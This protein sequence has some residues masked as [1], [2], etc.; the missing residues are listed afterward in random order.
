MLIPI[1]YKK[2][3][4]LFFTEDYTEYVKAYIA[5]LIWKCIYDK[6]IC[7]LYLKCCSPA[8]LSTISP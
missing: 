7:L 2:I 8:S 3:L 4:N 1:A 6:S 5:K